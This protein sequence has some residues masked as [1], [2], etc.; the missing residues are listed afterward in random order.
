MSR[1]SSRGDA[2][3]GDSFTWIGS[4]QQYLELLKTAY[5]A[6]KAA[7]PNATVIFGATSYWVDINIGRQPFF[8]LL[9]SGL[10]TR[11]L[12]NVFFDVAAFNIYWC[13]DDLL[14]VH[15]EMKQAMNKRGMDKPIWITETNAMPFDDGATPKSPN[16][17]RVTME[18]QADFAIQALA[19]SSAA[20]YQR[21]GWYRMTDGNIWQQQEVWGL[22]RDNGSPRPVFQAMKTALPLFAGAGKVTFVPLD[23]ETQAWG[24]P[25]PQDPNSYYPNWR[26]TR[27]SSTI[28]MAAG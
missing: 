10:S 1:S 17:Q 16:G 9:P 8:S 24:T 25:W 3:A 11:V 26:S 28:R 21:I 19:L 20:G 15:R 6:I 27:W 2:G 12:A 23:R 4:D 14:R 5:Q 18:Q 7:N 22:V 13:P